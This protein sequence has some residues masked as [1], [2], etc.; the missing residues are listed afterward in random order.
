MTEIFGSE[1][2]LQPVQISACGQADL[3]HEDQLRALLRLPS[4]RTAA[5]FHAQAAAAAD[6]FMRAYAP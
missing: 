4:D 5:E 1:T 3:N 6:R 2:S